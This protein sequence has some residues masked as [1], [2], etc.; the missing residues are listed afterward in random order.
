MFANVKP[1]TCATEMYPAVPR[2]TP[3]RSAITGIRNGEAAKCRAIDDAATSNAGVADGRKDVRRR[4]GACIDARLEPGS[5]D[6]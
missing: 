4:L 3:N 2:A 1:P 6:A 5:R